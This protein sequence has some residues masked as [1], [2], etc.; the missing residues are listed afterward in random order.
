[1]YIVQSQLGYYAND[2]VPAWVEDVSKAKRFSKR[3]IATGVVRI[4]KRHS[5]VKSTVRMVK[6]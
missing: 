5:G 3:T 2:G 4:I 1:M 6:S